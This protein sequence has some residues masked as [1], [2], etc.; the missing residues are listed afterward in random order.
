[1]GN[2]AERKRSN[3]WHTYSD[4]MAFMELVFIYS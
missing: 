3:D 4:I 1:M 2:R